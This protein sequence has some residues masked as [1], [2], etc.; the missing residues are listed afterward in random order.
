MLDAN[1]GRPEAAAAIWMVQDAPGQEPASAG[2]TRLR[3]A[4]QGGVGL[5]VGVAVYSFVSTT[6]GLVIG[7]IG[8]AIALAAL[9]SPSGLYAAIERAF[10]ALGHVIGRGLTWVLMA[11]VFYGMITPFGLLF[12]R[13]RRDPMRRALHTS[14]DSYWEPREIG[15]SGSSSRTL[16]Y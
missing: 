9:I 15:R 11:G 4:L 5:A 1:A 6:A 12:R 3:G 2:R 7:C 8:S 13:G 10:A 16:Q 14:A